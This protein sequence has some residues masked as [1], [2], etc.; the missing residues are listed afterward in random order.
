MK[1]SDREATAITIIVAL[2]STVI[3]GSFFGAIGLTFS[4]LFLIGFAATR[5]SRK[6]RSE[7]IS[8]TI[9]KPANIKHVR[10]TSPHRNPNGKA[11]LRWKG[12]GETVAVGEF[13]I[14]DPM[15]YFSEDEPYEDEASCINKSLEIG[16]SENV[17]SKL[18]Y[19]PAYVSMVPN[20]RAYYLRWLANGRKDPLTDIGYAF[21]YF[22]GLERRL[23]AEH[24]SKDREDILDETSRLLNLYTFSKSFDDYLSKFLV[25]SV[26]APGIG[27]ELPEERFTKI[28]EKTRLQVDENVLAVALAWLIMNE[29]PIPVTWATWIA[30]FD[31]RTPDS[32]IPKRNPDEFRKL[33]AERYK[34]RFGNGLVVK[35]KKK[36]L[37]PLRVI[38]YKP[39]NISKSYEF[40]FN[41]SRPLR[42][43]P[44]VLRLRDKFTLILD[45]WND[46]V[47]S[48]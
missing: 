7:N 28:F 12:K 48:S 13:I 36:E 11:L 37:K 23:L 15:T 38:H 24:Q 4:T 3:A 25:Y 8:T 42:R 1:F 19:Y 22:Y 46:C 32:V 40:Y 14:S 20:Q 44:D 29:R 45:V 9:N 35:A 47:R 18:E 26:A 16:K 41:L 2:I 34:E 5:I 30:K 10:N 17:Q 39:A 21:V 33:F 27:Q 43:V 6:T 31:G